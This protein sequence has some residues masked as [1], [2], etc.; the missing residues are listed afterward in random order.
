[1]YHSFEER[2][3]KTDILLQ[4]IRLDLPNLEKLLTEE[5]ENKWGKEDLLYRYYH[6]SF[7]VYDIQYLT[8]KIY[9]AL[10]K[11][12]PHEAYKNI[13]V[14]KIFQEDNDSESLTKKRRIF[15]DF[16]ENIVKE[17]TGKK[18]ILEHNQRWEAECR[19]MLEAFFHARYFL[20]M[21]V[22]YGKEL[23]PQD[24]ESVQNHLSSG[25]AAL[26]ELYEVR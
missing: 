23:D 15:C 9:G 25:W 3:R 13:R 10:A 2:Q 7:K 14:D 5:V 21:A 16:F 18:W 17:G 20:E 24:K 4:N 19:P 26:L 1:M 6:F 22:K 11:L 8:E 12:S